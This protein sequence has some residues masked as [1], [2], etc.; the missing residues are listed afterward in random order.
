MTDEQVANRGELAQELLRNPL[1][2]EAQDELERRLIAKM[3]RIDT[4]KDDAEYLRTIMIGS[5]HYRKFFEA[6]VIMGRNVELE[7]DRKKTL[8]ERLKARYAA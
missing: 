1:F 5:K 8:A 4:S 6:L 7:I 2:K 3:A